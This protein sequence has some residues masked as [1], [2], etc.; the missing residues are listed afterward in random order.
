NTALAAG[1]I[2]YDGSTAASMKSKNI[3]IANTLIGMDFGIDGAL[4]AAN[5]DLVFGN[6]GD[7]TVGGGTNLAAGV[8]DSRINPIHFSFD[9]QTIAYAASI[10]PDLD[11]G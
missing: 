2:A 9:T 11:L 3:V 8:L 10:T 4:S 6:T 7:A 5:G 1:G